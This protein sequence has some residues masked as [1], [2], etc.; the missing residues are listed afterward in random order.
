MKAG[1][2]IAPEGAEEPMTIVPI[3]VDPL[4]DV[5]KGRTGAGA[6]TFL[7]TSDGEALTRRCKHAARLLPE[8][9]QA[10]E[11]QKEDAPGQLF[12]LTD[13]PADDAELIKQVL[14]EGEVSG[15][16]ALPD[17]V[18]AQ[19]QEA[20]MAGLWRVRFTGQD[21]KLIADYLEVSS[22]PEIVRRG[23]LVNAR[24]LAYGQA[25]QGAMNVMPLLKEIETRANAHQ[26]GQPTHTV[27]FSLLPMSAE[28]MDYLQQ[29]LG[30]GPVKLF[31]KGYSSCRAVATATK[32]VWSVQYFNTMDTIILDTLEIGDPPAAVSAA[33]EDFKD[34]AERMREID[35]A[36]FK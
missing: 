35:E 10:L 31:S 30:A 16:V 13:F 14:G 24:P 5:D 25:P 12:D 4:A 21:G 34:S 36:Y 11:T 1:F 20:T 7:A 32:N 6:V 29:C 18:T 22:L 15:L 2:W 8:L 27:T 28:D 3:N 9:A 17:G 19:I 23:A 33:A 26:P